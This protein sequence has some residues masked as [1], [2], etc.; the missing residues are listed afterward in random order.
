MLKHSGWCSHRHKHKT[1]PT[2]K[3]TVTYVFGN[4]FHVICDV[5]FAVYFCLLHLHSDQTSRKRLDACFLEIHVLFGRRGPR[6]LV[7]TVRQSP[8]SPVQGNPKAALFGSFWGEPSMSPVQCLVQSTRHGC[9]CTL[10]EFAINIKT[11]PN[12]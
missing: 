9:E 4:F 2:L 10:L 11:N 6:N 12:C 3:G 5:F 1:R 7:R 8:L